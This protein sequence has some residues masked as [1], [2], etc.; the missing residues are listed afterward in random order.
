M[1]WVL[2]SQPELTGL[3]AK[4]PD[5]MWISKNSLEVFV[6]LVEIEAPSKPWQTKDGRPSAKLTQAIDQL[7]D[8]KSWFSDERNVLRFKA[9]YRIEEHTLYTR[10]FS[11]QYTLIYGREQEATSTEA[12][13]KKR[14]SYDSGDQTVMSY[15]RLK[16]DPTMM[17]H[18]TVRLDRSGPDLKMRM[19]H[20]PA[21]FKLGPN[22]ARD[23][24][25]LTQRE[26]AIQKNPWLSDERKEFLI[27]RLPYWDG[28]SKKKHLGIVSSR[29]EE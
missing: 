8:W 17:C 3:K 25:R 22:V 16:P 24:A 18:P 28:W 5:F 11:Q 1:H 23:W 20:I 12:F 13:A 6:D 10:A 9:D 29:D 14:V 19:L 15:D 26:E 21:T 2:I 7:H 4:R 27:Q